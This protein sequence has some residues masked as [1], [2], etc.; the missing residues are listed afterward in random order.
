M[1]TFDCGDEALNRFL[2]RFTQ[3]NQ[4][5]RASR[6]YVAL[7]GDSVVGFHTLVV[8]E[9]SLSRPPNASARGWR[10]TRFR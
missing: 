9:V 1:E 8:G 6:T 4:R 7:A 10:A 2:F 3:P 5:A